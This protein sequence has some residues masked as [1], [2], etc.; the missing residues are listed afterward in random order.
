MKD[1]DHTRTSPCS[2]PQ[3]A[4]TR[5]L[6][7][8]ILWHPARSHI[9]AQAIGPLG[10]GTLAVGRHAPLFYCLDASQVALASA[11]ISRAPLLL[12]RSAADAV[13]LTA[14]ASRMTVLVDG[15]RLEGSMQL[16]P[17]QV[18]R[19]VVLEL[20][21]TVL[22]CLHWMLG[23]PKAGCG[24]PILGVSDG[25]IGLRELVRQVAGTALPVLLL[26]ETGS[27]KEVAARA[28]HAASDRRNRPW[29]AVNMAALNESLA[30]ADLFGAEKGA[31]TGAQEA[32]PGLFAE[33]RGSTLF[34]DEIGDTPAAIQP[35]LLRVLESGEYRPLG[36]RANLASTA[37]LIAA[38]DQDLQSRAFNQPLL[39][40]LEAFV[41]ALPP[42]RARRPDIGL[43]I[44]HAMAS[45]GRDPA[46]L[47]IGVASAMCRF[48]WPGNVRQLLHVV[49]R[50]QLAMPGDAAALFDA[51]VATP[52]AP[53]AATPAAAKPVRQRLERISNQAVL[54]AMAASRWRVL[55][56][57]RWLGVS[58]PS[59]YKLLA[60]HPQIR[61]CDAIPR[62]ELACAL[63]LHGHDLERCAAQLRTPLEAL[64]RHALS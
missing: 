33:A 12:E 49:Q 32:R 39:R 57:A 13:T 59:M 61:Q 28:I 6:G 64:R 8:T 62:E 21:A 43:L 15:V 31:Y 16:A 17:S 54:D 11:C 42:L 55:G 10:M 44:A 9:G 14:P 20:G 52:S 60:R 34:L 38:T 48:D 47:P 45:A 22:V 5:I 58:R 30:A 18:A 26:G 25:A 3:N 37:R 7:L 35:M 29:V 41:I 4:S 2:S 19:G 50:L 51:L 63:A 40:R 23:L 46:T 27:G 56:A 53:Q 24:S 1:Q 36:A